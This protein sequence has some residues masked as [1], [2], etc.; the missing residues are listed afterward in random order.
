MPRAA[1]CHRFGEPLVVEEVEL[2]RPAD[3]EVLVD[4]RACAVCHSDLAYA[5]G[6]WGGDLPA[7][8]GHEACGVVAQ[9]GPGVGLAAGQRVV[10]SLIR[11]CGECPRCRDRRPALCEARFR[12]DDASP[13]R[14][15][16]GRRAVQ[17]V[18]CGA[19][20]DAA[21]VHASQAVPL[22]DGVPDESACLLACAVMTGVGAAVHDANV[23]P[24]AAVAVI[25]AGG[26]GLNAIQGAVLAGAGS[27]IAVDVS[28]SRLAAAGAFGA[29]S[30]IDASAGDVPERVRAETAGAGADA[31]IVTTAAPSSVADG[32]ACVRRGGTLVCVGMPAGG[33]EAAFAPGALAHDG[34]RIV[35]SK[36]GSSLPA[37]DVPRLAGLYA[38]GRLRLDEL[39][40]ATFP[41]E[42]INDALAAMRSG[43]AIRA[44]VVP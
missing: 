18:R 16:D 13:I 20:A 19:F 28:A 25:G 4:L 37:R 40:T 33:A 39:V 8:Y 41:L 30:A 35:G 42:R 14:L 15:A 44:V 34:I 3:G 21:V 6:A 24:G 9:A 10:V 36:L 1:V 22:P 38:A 5:D 26:V 27:V 17:G 23:A 2:D 43:A 31:V 7:V 11:S 32:L 12:L 29:T